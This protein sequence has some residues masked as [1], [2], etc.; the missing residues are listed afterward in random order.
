MGGIPETV[1][2]TGVVELPLPSFMEGTVAR[3][4]DAF[5]W[6][7]HWELRE[8]SGA[9]RDMGRSTQRIYT[10]FNPPQ[11]PWTTD[12]GKPNAPWI[13]VLEYACQWARS[14]KTTGD[15]ASMIARALYQM[16][17][18]SHQGGALF[19][20]D[21]DGDSYGT[22]G[23]YLASSNKHPVNRFFLDKFLDRLNGGEGS[24]SQI[25]CGGTASAL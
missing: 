2:N 18:R 6:G 11:S 22:A 15:A 10:V 17:R 4:I 20:Y 3:G 7:L 21:P 5:D 9:W 8:E 12:E 14:A 1:V 24:G 25:S 16:A 13:P 19:I 23:S